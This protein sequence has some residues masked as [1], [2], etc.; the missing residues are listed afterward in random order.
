MWSR[1]NG[2]IELHGYSYSNFFFRMATFT[3]FHPK[4][5]R[6]KWRKTINSII[7]EQLIR[8][9]V[10]LDTKK[11]IVCKQLYHSDKRRTS[12]HYT[13]PCTNQVENIFFYYHVT[14]GC[15][16]CYYAHVSYGVVFRALCMYLSSTI[17]NCSLLWSFW[18]GK[19]WLMS[20]EDFKILHCYRPLFLF[21]T[22]SSK[23]ISN[24]YTPHTI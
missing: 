15:L 24:N 2:A 23:Y 4:L 10:T 13:T 9:G 22:I 17:Y 18:D 21:T 3:L 6:H 7:K 1:C 19:Y 12:T 16:L 11:S 14:I 5:I 20:F 8:N